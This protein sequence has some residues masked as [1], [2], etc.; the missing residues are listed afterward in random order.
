MSPALSSEFPVRLKKSRYCCM[1]LHQGV[2]PSFF[3]EQ[4]AAAE[5][6]VVLV[7]SA[8][9]PDDADCM[10]GCRFFT[11]KLGYIPDLDPDHQEPPTFQV[12]AVTSMLHRYTLCCH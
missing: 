5:M 8:C 12:L 4:P 11:R 3:L 7:V 10:L 6:L 2:A 1:H 9:L